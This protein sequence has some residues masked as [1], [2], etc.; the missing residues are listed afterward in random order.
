MSPPDDAP[1]LASLARWSEWW[2]TPRWCALLTWFA[3][4]AITIALRD[5]NAYRF[6]AMTQQPI[7]YLQRLLQVPLLP[8]LHNM[9]YTLTVWL[10]LIWFQPLALRLSLWRGMAWI[11]LPLVAEILWQVHIAFAGYDSQWPWF[12]I[13]CGSAALQ[14]WV[15]WG[16]RSRPW[17]CLP[18]Q[19]A[20]SALMI[21]ASFLPSLPFWLTR[22]VN[23][24]PQ[25]ALLL[26]GT[27][28]L[29]PQDRA[30]GSAA[31]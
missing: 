18:A 14:C 20:T 17:M 27:R 4:T 31:E 9:A 25:A 26:Y 15:L 23:T 13:Q 16:W 6:N 21:S 10:L 8:V 3:L 28:L 5:A 11:S 2:F 19:A 7:T 1:P 30:G 24:L 22:A 12:A 29:R